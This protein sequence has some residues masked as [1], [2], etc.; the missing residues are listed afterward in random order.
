MRHAPPNVPETKL[1]LKPI[2]EQSIVRVRRV[3]VC[4]SVMKTVGIR[5]NGHGLGCKMGGDNRPGCR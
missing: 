4:V 1:R 3:C 2:D 5:D